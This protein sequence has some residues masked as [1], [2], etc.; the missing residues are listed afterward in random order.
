VT[1]ITFLTLLYPHLG[2]NPGACGNEAA[3]AALTLK[4]Q[5]KS[6]RRRDLGTPDS[7]FPQ[8]DGTG[9]IDQFKAWSPALPAQRPR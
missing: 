6:A 5:S 3:A 1:A 8:P 7:A 2:D 9:T 4:Y